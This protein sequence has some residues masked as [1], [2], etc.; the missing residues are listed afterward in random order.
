MRVQTFDRAWQMLAISAMLT[1]IVL[2]I[3]MLAIDAFE[4][5][6]SIV[7]KAEIWSPNFRAQTLG[8]KSCISEVGCYLQPPIK[9]LNQPAK[10]SRDSLIEFFRRASWS[11]DEVRTV[12]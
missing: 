1:I 2:A 4:W 8:S 5:L 10:D 12:S 6:A 3:V 11:F 9:N 7:W